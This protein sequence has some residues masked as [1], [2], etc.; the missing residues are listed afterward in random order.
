MGGSE[1]GWS[2]HNDEGVFRDY[3]KEAERLVE[4]GK[5]FDLEPIIYNNEFIY[6][7][8]YYEDHKDVL[9]K[10]SFGFAYKAICIYETMK[11]M[12]DGDVLIWADSNHIVLQNP[13]IFI[14]TALEYG[15]FVRDH[16]WVYYPQKDW[17]RRDTFVNMGCDE[18][19]Y[20]NAPQL[21][22]NVVAFCKTERM[23]NFVTEWK[24]N[25]LRYEVMFGNNEYPDFPSL[26]EHRHNQAIFSILACKYRL[27][28][29]NR[30]ENVRLEYIIPEVEYIISDHPVDNSYRKEIDRKDNK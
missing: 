28:Y 5:Q 27:P 12:E 22:D 7:L 2:R 9:T 14:N 4:S 13:E 11:K 30:S 17:C 25:C 19:L 20:H 26:K 21:Q 6:N 10:V 29:L 1:F 18:E 3:Q 24:D 15:A 8:P 16:I 23:M